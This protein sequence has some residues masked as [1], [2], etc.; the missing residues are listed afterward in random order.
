MKPDGSR[1]FDDTQLELP[2][3][4]RGELRAMFEPRGPLPRGVDEAIRTL[5][6][7][8]IGGSR[9]TVIRRVVP[10]AAAAAAVLLAVFVWPARQAAPG[11][12]AGAETA[13]AKA[14]RFVAREDVDG[15]GR[16]NIVDALVLARHVER[17]TAQGEWDINRDG[18]VD[19]RD[20]DA[21]AQAAVS[22]TGG[23]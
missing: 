17:G 20:A 19:R 16:V 5:A 1:Q 18:H 22:L 12:P 8:E 13:T 23:I 9:R 4:L 7:R 2:E 3:G 10:I 21:V 15:S 14:L 11:G 6:R